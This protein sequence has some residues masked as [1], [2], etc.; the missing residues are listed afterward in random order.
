MGDIGGR[1]YLYYAECEE[2]LHLRRGLRKLT[3]DRQADWADYSIVMSQQFYSSGRETMVQWKA[4]LEAV[5]PLVKH[6]GYL[7]K[8]LNLVFV[9][10]II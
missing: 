9:E 7:E 2:R 8:V 5:V 6:E 10:S 4:N 1:V 3:E